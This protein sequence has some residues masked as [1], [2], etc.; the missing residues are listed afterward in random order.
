M[1]DIPAPTEAGLIQRA[2]KL[3]DSIAGRWQAIV[4]SGAAWL[5]RTDWLVLAMIFM[6]YCQFPSELRAFGFKHLK[7]IVAVVLVVRVLVKRQVYS[8][9]LHAAGLILLYCA[10]GAA[11]VLWAEDPSRAEAMALQ[12]AKGGALFVL[13][14]ASLDRPEA[15]RRSA[16]AVVAAGLLMSLGPIYQRLSGDYDNPLWGFGHGTIA[17][18]W[19]AIDGYRLSGTLS[20]PNSFAEALVPVLALGFGLLWTEQK[21]A[22]CLCAA[23]AMVA[24]T[25]GV[26]LS[27]SRAGALGVAVVALLVV[28]AFRPRLRAILIFVALALAVSPAI[29]KGYINRMKTFQKFTP[30]RHAELLTEPGFKGRVSEVWSGLQMF[31]DHPLRGVGLG[32]YEVYYQRYS[33]PLGID[34]RT[35]EREAHSLPVE[36]A[37]ETGILGLAAFGLF[38]AAVLGRVIRAR[39][40]LLPDSQREAAL[41]SAVAVALLGYLAVSL[42]LQ[43]NYVSLFWI[44][45]AIAHATQRSFQRSAEN[46]D[47]HFVAEQR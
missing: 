22:L 33:R 43:S 37:A 34:R 16:W 47:R 32:N 21:L 2:P 4:G 6:I 27:Y 1:N 42:T 18:I 5:L 30:S 3:A 7:A 46:V 40:L 17:H 29:D 24:V 26:I 10:V 11:S 25:I 45:A 39:R 19:G 8:E 13:V 15:I 36:I 20:D 38:L 9:V 28:F 31:R 35:E 14:S 41:V 23:G 44:L 12:I